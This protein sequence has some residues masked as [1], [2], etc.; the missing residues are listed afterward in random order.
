MSRRK[1]GSRKAKKNYLNELNKLYKKLKK[2]KT[3]EE[4]GVIR[5]KRESIK[6]KIR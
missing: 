6:Q 3:D 5:Q 2:C 4:K 1:N